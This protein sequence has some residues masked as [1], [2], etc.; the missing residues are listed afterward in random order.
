M[1]L[2][3][4]PS[5]SSSLSDLGQ[6]RHLRKEVG[7]I[8]STY[9]TFGGITV[10]P[11]RPKTTWSA[12]TRNTATITT[13]TTTSKVM[14]QPQQQQLQEPLVV[15]RIPSAANK[16]TKDT[17]LCLDAGY[18]RDVCTDFTFERLEISDELRNG[19]QFHSRMRSVFCMGVV[20]TVEIEEIAEELGKV[21]GGAEITPAFQ[22]NVPRNHIL[23]DFRG[24]FLFLSAILAREKQRGEQNKRAPSSTTT[25]TPAFTT[26]DQ[27]FTTPNQFSTVEQ[28]MQIDQQ[29][30][31]PQ[32]TVPNVE[33]MED[34]PASTDS[35]GSGNKLEHHTDA[36]ANAFVLATFL[37]LQEF[38]ATHA[39]YKYPMRIIPEYNTP[40]FVNYPI[41]LTV[42]LLNHRILTHE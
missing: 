12:N 24:C 20:L 36:F 34:S 4:S 14:A 7:P 17:V 10:T 41:L 35:H 8:L 37:S 31:S 29:H 40:P 25:S 33:A 11:A 13:T 28:P 39:W 21:N 26:P 19:M 32:Q 5:S 42:L 3:T 22:L 2:R 30:S 9:R 15:E 23:R 1:S 18:E 6:H 38:L 16:W 27:Q